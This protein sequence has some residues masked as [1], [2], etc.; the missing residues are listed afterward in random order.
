DA[1]IGPER[2]VLD[3]DRRV[4]HLLGAG[5]EAD[6][7]AALI[8]ERVEEVLSR[9]VVDLGRQGDRDGR[10]VVR[11]R[12]VRG[13]IAEHRRHRD[14]AHREHRQEERADTAGQR[15]EALFCCGAAGMSLALPLWVAI[16]SIGYP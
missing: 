14:T 16:I 6:E 4:L 12:K 15:A 11:R 2:F 9:A 13:E 10:E 1:R 5:I 8:L 7:L 3:S